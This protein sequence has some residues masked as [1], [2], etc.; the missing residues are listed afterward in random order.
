MPENRASSLNG[1]MSSR[2]KSHLDGVFAANDDSD[3]CGRSSK[4]QLH[5]LQ[6]ELEDGQIGCHYA[7]LVAWPYLNPEGTE[8]RLFGEAD[9]W[10]GEKFVMGHWLITVRGG[11]LHPVFDQICQAKRWSLKVSGVVE[12]KEKPEVLR[13]EVERA[14]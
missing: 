1:D 4:H 6:I 3:S 11:R 14:G 13:I 12:N 10:D 9:R 8:M 7:S 5:A 2:G